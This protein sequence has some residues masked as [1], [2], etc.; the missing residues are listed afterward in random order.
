MSHLVVRREPQRAGG[1]PEHARSLDLHRY[2]PGL[3]VRVAYQFLGQG[4]DIDAHDLLLAVLR[5][6]RT[7]PTNDA[8]A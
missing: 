1:V 6:D 5:L 4:R 7:K 2:E 3:A 8:V